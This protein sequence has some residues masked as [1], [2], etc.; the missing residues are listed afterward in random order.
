MQGAAAKDKDHTKDTGA[1]A[2]LKES[3]RSVVPEVLKG[4]IGAPVK[5]AIEAVLP[6]AAQE[7]VQAAVSQAVGTAVAAAVESDTFKTSVSEVVGAKLVEREKALV[8]YVHTAL[9]QACN[10]IVEAVVSQM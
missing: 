4:E 3:I 1:R 7:A 2:D 10:W 6:A 8:G 9:N 5:D